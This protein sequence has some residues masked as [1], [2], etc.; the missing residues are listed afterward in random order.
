LRARSAAPPPP[1]PP[2]LGAVYTVFSCADYPDGEGWNRGAVLRLARGAAPRPVEFSLSSAAEPKA[3]TGWGR[4]QRQ[5][6][7]ELVL[8]YRHQLR[9]TF[10]DAAPGGHAERRLEPR[11]HTQP[12]AHPSV[13]RSTPSGARARA[14]ASR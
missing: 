8:S 14:G 12:A 3:D 1:H 11:A 2:R 5:S 4:R 13:L 6:L 10:E 7:D 9:E